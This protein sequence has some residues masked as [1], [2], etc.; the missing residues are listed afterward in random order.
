MLVVDFMI[1]I[2]LVLMALQA[3]RDADSF[4]GI[5]FFMMFGLVLALAW[6]RLGAPDVAL[7][8]AAIGSGL[9]G[10]LFIAAWHELNPRNSDP[11]PEEEPNE[12]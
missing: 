7:A 1:A 3:T 8:E 10:A 12:D 11:E 4:R 9:T 2:T 6:L 5:V